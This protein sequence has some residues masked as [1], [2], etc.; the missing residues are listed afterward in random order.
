VLS[1]NGSMHFTAYADPVTLPEAKELPTLLS[2]ALAEMLE[3][4]DDGAERE[5]ARRTREFARRRRS[6]AVV[7]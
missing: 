3:A 4:C 6:P 5:P 7:A 1:Y 2:V